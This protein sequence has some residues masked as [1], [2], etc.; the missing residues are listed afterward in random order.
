MNADIYAN[1][2][3][4]VMKP[5]RDMVAVGRKYV[6]HLDSASAHKAKRTPSWLTLNVTNH[7]NSVTGRVSSKMNL[8]TVSTFSFD[9]HSN[10][11]NHE[12]SDY[13]RNYGRVKH[14]HVSAYSILTEDLAIKR[15]AAKFV[16]ML[17]TA[18]QLGVEVLKDMLDFTNTDFMD[19]IITG[20][21]G[22]RQ[23]HSNVKVMLTAFFDSSGVVHHATTVSNKEYYRDVLRRLRDAMRRKRPELWSTGN[24]HLH[25]DNATA[26]SSH[27]IQTVLHKTQTSVVLQASYSP[28]IA[29]CDF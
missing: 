5:W 19:I 17:M 24:C 7:L 29:P 10:L 11:R 27:L 28:D 15:V 12:S 13:P 6:F 23:V 14:L 18:E 4:A 25:H 20:V 1:V 8:A 16:P 3:E 2:L 22:V 26:H 9:S 21:L